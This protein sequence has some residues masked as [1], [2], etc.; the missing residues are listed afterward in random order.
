MSDVE[1]TVAR[2]SDNDPPEIGPES[3][4]GNNR[5][6]RQWDRFDEERLSRSS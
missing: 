5:E 1:H 2:Q 4:D 3:D 6:D